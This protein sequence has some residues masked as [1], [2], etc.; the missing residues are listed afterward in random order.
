LRALGMKGAYS[1]GVSRQQG[2][3]LPWLFELKE[4]ADR[5][6]TAFRAKPERQVWRLG[7]SKDLPAEWPSTEKDRQHSARDR[8]TARGYPI[9]D[10]PVAVAASPRGSARYAERGCGGL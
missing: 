10:R 8:K 4:D 1:V 6:A 7:Q 5:A 3:V 9:S 2:L